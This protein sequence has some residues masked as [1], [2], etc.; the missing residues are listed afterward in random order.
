[1]TFV[2]ES[3]TEVNPHMTFKSC[4]YKVLKYVNDLKTNMSTIL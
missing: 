3:C 2:G 1:M 4:K